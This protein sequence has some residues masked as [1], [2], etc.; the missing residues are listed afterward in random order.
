MPYSMGKLVYTLIS[1]AYFV[2][3]KW[4]FGS[5]HHGIL[6]MGEIAHKRRP[7][8]AGEEMM[9]PVTWLVSPKSAMIER[10]LF[11][12]FHDDFGDAVGYMLNKDDHSMD[13]NKELML[14]ENENDLKAHVDAEINTVKDILSWA[15]IKV[16][17]TGYRSTSLV[18][19]LAD[20][21]I[22][23]M[24]GSCP[25]QIGTDNITD[26]GA[27]WGQ[28]YVNPVNFKK[29][30]RTGGRVI[31][32][33]WTARDLNKA[34]H[35]A[36]PEAY[37]T[38]PND[39]ESQAKCTDENVEYWKALFGQYLR[40]L[41]LNDYIFFHQHQ[42]AHE[43]EATPT[44]IP[45]MQSGQGRIDYTAKMLSLFFD[46]V[47]AQENVIATTANGALEI[48]DEHYQGTQPPAYMYF[49]DIPIYE[50]SATYVN[51][52]KGTYQHPK[53]VWLSFNEEFFNKVDQFVSQ[54]D[55]LL[56]EPP[57]KHSFFY[58][59][60]D[61][62]LVFDQPQ[63]G[64]VWVCNYKEPRPT[65]DELLLSEEFIP[66]ASIENLGD[67]VK[68]LVTSSKPMPYG[69]AIWGNEF[70]EQ[71]LVPVEEGVKL[72]V[73]NDNLVFVRFDIF[74]GI[75]EIMLYLS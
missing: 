4:G 47:A 45:F 50:L 19:V 16:V 59:D 26:F 21:D 43:M 1:S 56:A 13:R 73:I 3:E 29:P 12:R 15:E 63:A 52:V 24:W 74:Q 11:T 2:D 23:G 39:V 57:W 36:Q 53:H 7:N 54:P 61:C 68:I 10:D 6:T 62:M 38:D 66:D 20:L 9:F 65:N 27:P 31:N 72:K 55:S 49:E 14:P 44:C 8:A 41:D 71:G 33:E 22:P 58:Y 75:N 25:F 17:G 5:P 34:F 64:P 32:I 28:W 46:H 67:V 70:F 35:Y 51:S 60:A 37:S 18:H 69:V 40:N 42:E 30:V 48:F